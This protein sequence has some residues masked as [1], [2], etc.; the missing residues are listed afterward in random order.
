MNTHK[1]AHTHTPPLPARLISPA[2]ISI[3]GLFQRGPNVLTTQSKG[4][5]WKE[6]D[7]ATG[8]VSMKQNGLSGVFWY[9]YADSYRKISRD[10]FACDDAG[11]V[12]LWRGYCAR[13]I[14]TPPE[15][16]VQCLQWHAETMF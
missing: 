8:V 16:L 13:S 2:T 9:T 14:L 4:G 10:F 7:K 5:G 3:K 6:G 15:T 12:Q 11:E 1:Q